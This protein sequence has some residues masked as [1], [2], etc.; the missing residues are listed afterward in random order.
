MHNGQTSGGFKSLAQSPKFELSEL[1]NS[2]LTRLVINPFPG[3]Y[4]VL[5]YLN[6]LLQIQS[7][8]LVSLH[9][10]ILLQNMTLK[11]CFSVI[12]QEKS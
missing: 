2:E 7:P 12:A 6:P 9:F 4:R 1:G 10:L 3:L 11:V 8:L 5:N